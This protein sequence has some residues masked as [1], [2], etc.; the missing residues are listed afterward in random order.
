MRGLRHIVRKNKSKLQ[1]GEIQL[2]PARHYG[3]NA[4]YGFDEC[5]EF[6]VLLKQGNRKIGEVALRIGESPQ[7]YYVGHIGYHIDKPFRGHSYA[8]AACS[9][10]MPLI[11]KCGL[12]SIVITADP[13]NLPSRRTI[14]KLGGIL[15]CSTP[16]PPKLQKSLLLSQ[17]KCRYILLA[18]SLK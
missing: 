5:M 16:V 11:G 4:L 10:M 1:N 9:L 17:I 15:E 8:Y 12:G 3:R 14:E 6:D 2:L 18:H 7:M 13:D